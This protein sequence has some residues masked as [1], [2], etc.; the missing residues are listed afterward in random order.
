MF[1][2]PDAFSVF[3]QHYPRLVSIDLHGFSRNR[4]NFFEREREEMRVLTAAT[5]IGP[6]VWVSHTALP[7]IG[8]LSSSSMLTWIR[9][10]QLGNSQDVPT[11]RAAHARS[12]SMDSASSLVSEDG[13]PCSFSI[14]IESHDQAGLVSR[15]VLESATQVLAEL[16]QQGRVCREVQPVLTA[17][18]EVVESA[19]TLLRPPVEEVVHLETTSTAA[20]LGTSS[21]AQD[22]FV[23]H[24]VELAVWIRDQSDPNPFAAATSDCPLQAPR[25]VLLHCGDGYTETSLLA[26]AYVM[27]ARRCSVSEAYLFLQLDCQRSFFVYTADRETVLKLERRVVE[28]L[29]REDDEERYTRRWLAEQRAVAIVGAARTA[30]LPRS[31]AQA[32]DLARVAESGAGAASA[33]ED[34]T[35]TLG[36]SSTSMGRSDSGFVDSTGPE[37]AT[38]D[39]LSSVDEA[40]LRYALEDE[41]ARAEAEIE[42]ACGG[43]KRRMR[44]ADPV[45]DAWFFGPTF[46]GHFPSRIL[47]H[48]VSLTGPE[49]VPECQTLTF[50]DLRA[51]QYLGNVKHASN[52]LMLKELGITHVVSMGET[53]L[54]PPRAPTGLSL[55]TSTFRS[56]ATASSAPV[57]SLWEEEQAGTISVLD[58]QDVAD[59]GID[60]IRPCIDEALE[61]IRAARREGGTVLVHCKVGVSRSASIVIAYL[62][63]EMGLDLASSY[64]LTRSR[65]LNILVQPNLPFVAALHAFEAELLED[66]ERAIAASRPRNPPGHSPASSVGSASEYGDAVSDAAGPSGSH[67]SDDDEHDSL[68]VLGQPGL[69]RSNRLAFSFLC[70]EIARLNERF[71]G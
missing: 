70:G 13:N 31:Q 18:N 26:L 12:H 47:P 64:L 69:K 48:L 49:G 59:D 53:A 42:A 37:A 2:S 57:N 30:C 15:E 67:H 38:L 23:A 29:A 54:H 60:S 33:A 32:Q 43:P 19:T 40:K 50:E 5:E 1:R 46:E 10:S 62:M 36:L 14:C 20:A 24:I 27:L 66:K 28:V 35:V 6:N 17:D 55:L 25:R 61:F 22:A 9:T 11:I 58:M 45:Q 8:L 16:E 68:Q 4:L 3:E 52:A 21:R 44:A 34:E 65:R 51:T 39:G 71:L 7:R 63:R 41:A 56:S